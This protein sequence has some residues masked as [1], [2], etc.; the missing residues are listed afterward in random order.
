MAPIGRGRRLGCGVHHLSCPYRGHMPVLRAPHHCTPA[1]GC[2]PPTARDRP[3]SRPA[4]PQ[5]E[6]MS[7]SSQRFDR[8]RRARRARTTPNHRHRRRSAQVAPCRSGTSDRQGRQLPCQPLGGAGGPTGR[9]ASPGPPRQSAPTAERPQRGRHGSLNLRPSKVDARAACDLDARDR[10]RRRDRL[11]QVPRPARLHVVRQLLALDVA[12]P[13]PDPHP[14]R[15]TAATRALRE[16]D[17]RR[18]RA[19]RPTRRD[20]SR[21]ADRQ[22]R[23]RPRRTRP[24]AALRPHPARCAAHNRRQP[25]DRPCSCSAPRSSAAGGR[26]RPARRGRVP[27]AAGRRS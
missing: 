7:P 2:P 18:A 21:T 22:R 11:Q 14:H 24:P 16:A 15:A 20:R 5:P 27:A 10:Q 9:R 17:H 4:G 26:P 12:Q 6:V 23:G 1:R 13:P 25:R 19:A 8:G 3:L